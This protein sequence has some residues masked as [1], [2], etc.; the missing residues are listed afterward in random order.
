M[1]IKFF[2]KLVF[3]ELFFLIN[4]SLDVRYLYKLLLI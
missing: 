3:I 2:K 1:F 4:N